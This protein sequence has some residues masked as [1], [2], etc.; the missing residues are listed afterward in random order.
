MCLRNGM[1]VHHHVSEKMVGVA[2]NRVHHHV[3]D[4]LFIIPCLINGRCGL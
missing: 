1:G 3:S 2:S 4:C